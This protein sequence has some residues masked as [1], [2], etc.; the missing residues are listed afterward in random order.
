M[1]YFHFFRDLS[2]TTLQV[3]HVEQLGKNIV[4]I[5][6]KMEK[7]FPPSYFDVMEHLP[8]HLAYEALMGGLCRFR[9]MFL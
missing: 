4:E 5:M 1:E 6:C 2:A 7:I 9:W 3:D 8:Q